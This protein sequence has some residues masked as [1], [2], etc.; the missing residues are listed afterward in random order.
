MKQDIVNNKS[1]AGA[2]AS[3][4]ASNSGLENESWI[5]LPGIGGRIEGLSRAAVYRLIDDP[6]SG[7]VSVSMTNPGAARGIR[8]VGLNSLRACIAR[9]ATEQ[10]ANRI[11]TKGDLQ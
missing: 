3:L 2:T 5:R 9:R 4:P 7:V 10:L 8:L 11:A 1:G 6:A